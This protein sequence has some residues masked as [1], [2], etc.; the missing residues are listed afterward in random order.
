M[1]RD[2]LERCKLCFTYVGQGLARVS[3]ELELALDEFLGGLGV[4]R[5]LRYAIRSV[6]RRFRHGEEETGP[7]RKE[8]GR[9]LMMVDGCEGWRKAISVPN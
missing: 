5:G 1:V 7:S 8:T 4:D 6:K 9:V 2:L 3:F